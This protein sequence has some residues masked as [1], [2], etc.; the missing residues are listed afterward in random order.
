MPQVVQRHA[1]SGLEQG[2]HIEFGLAGVSGRVT[3]V[4]LN[5]VSPGQRPLLLL[6][7]IE[8]PP[9]PRGILTSGLVYV[10]QYGTQTARPKHD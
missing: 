1:R 8:L 3:P 7:Q 5:G 10:S 9:F 4:P 6:V 2:V